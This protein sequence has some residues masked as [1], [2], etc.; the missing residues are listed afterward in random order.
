MRAFFSAAWLKA[1]WAVVRRY[2]EQGSYMVRTDL[3]GAVLVR[4]GSSGIETSGSRQLERRYSQG[5]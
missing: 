3:A 1:W 2:R 4:M 5:R